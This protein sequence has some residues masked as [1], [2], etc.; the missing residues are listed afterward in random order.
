[1]P[2]GTA[3]RDADGLP[4]DTGSSRH[5]EDAE[6]WAATAFPKWRV[7][8]HR[9]RTD[10]ESRSHPQITVDL[11]NEWT[12]VGPDACSRDC[13]DVIVPW[14]MTSRPSF[15]PTQMRSAVLR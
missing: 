3:T 9:S 10:P 8:V 15:V 12:E 2:H 13:I 1:M 11:L 4:S 7:R 14:S 5:R 6:R